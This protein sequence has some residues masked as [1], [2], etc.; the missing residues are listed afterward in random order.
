MVSSSSSTTRSSASPLGP[1]F[2]RGIL[3]AEILQLAE[4][5]LDLL[6]HVERLLPLSLAAL[7]SGDHQL[8]NLLA[9]RPVLPQPPAGLGMQ[10]LLDFGVDVESLLAT[11]LAPVGA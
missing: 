7:V 11:R 9:Q 10:Q 4:L 3:L 5:A 2:T 6:L 1:A 8:A